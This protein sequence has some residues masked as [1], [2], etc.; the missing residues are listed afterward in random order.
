MKI[1]YQMKAKKKQLN[2][3]WESVGLFVASIVLTAILWPIWIIYTGRKI[4]TRIFN[5]KPNRP[6]IKIIWYVSSLLKGFAKWIDQLGNSVCRD[7]FNDLLITRRGYRFGD[8]R[9]TISSV[10]WKNER[11]WTLTKTGEWLVNL[12]DKIEKDHCKKSIIYIIKDL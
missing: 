12:L 3:L 2:N 1:L 4:I 11:I 5:P 6:M 9:E 10:L 8:V 7:L